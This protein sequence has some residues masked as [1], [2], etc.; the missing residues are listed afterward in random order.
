V[1]TLGVHRD[2]P[3]Y[4]DVEL[5]SWSFYRSIPFQSP[6]LYLPLPLILHFRPLSSA[7]S[8]GVRL[9]HEFRGLTPANFLPVAPSSL[10]I[11]FMG[12]LSALTRAMSQF[13]RRARAVVS[14]HFWCRRASPRQGAAI[15]DCF[16]PSRYYPGS[17]T[18]ICCPFFVLLSL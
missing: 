5:S 15:M 3:L 11:F 8:K 18:R 17:L 2:C 4:K 13:I 6:H 10:P 9:L 7:A 16:R 14:L 12:L 1:V